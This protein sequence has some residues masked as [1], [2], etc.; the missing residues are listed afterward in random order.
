MKTQSKTVILPGVHGPEDGEVFN[1]ILMPSGYLCLFCRNRER[2]NVLEKK[3]N[4]AKTL[5][6]EN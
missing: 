1:W 6:P 3:V 2:L 5:F 4:M